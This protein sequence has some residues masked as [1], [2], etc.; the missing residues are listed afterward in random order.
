[1]VAHWKVC[2]E[3]DGRFTRRIIL[4]ARKK[5]ATLITEVLERRLMKASYL[6]AV[7]TLQQSKK[8][9]MSGR[10]KRICKKWIPRRAL[11]RVT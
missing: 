8:Q 7:S 9:T 11:E 10:P 1:M 6:S 3:E 5:R 4:S 2:D